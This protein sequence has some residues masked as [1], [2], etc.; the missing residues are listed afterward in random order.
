M[1]P[2]ATPAGPRATREEA[3]AW[4]LRRLGELAP[5]AAVTRQGDLADLG[6]TSL[7]I[8]RFAG[9]LRARFGRRVLAAEL[10][11]C[12]RLDDILSRLAPFETSA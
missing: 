6:L 4:I 11:E 5:D 1:R 8:V 9:E 2:P 10:F 3:E 12:R 7:Q